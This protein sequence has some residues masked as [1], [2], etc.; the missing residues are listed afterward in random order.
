MSKRI[1]QLDLDVFS[2]VIERH[3]IRAEVDI[4]QLGGNIDNETD[5]PVHMEFRVKLGFRD[6]IR[7]TSA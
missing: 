7:R 2:D 4:E 5:F 1:G 6:P 3:G